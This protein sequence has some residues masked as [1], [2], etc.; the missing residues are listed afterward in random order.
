MA[1]SSSTEAEEND[2]ASVHLGA[3]VGAV[4]AGFIPLNRVPRIGVPYASFL[5]SRRTLAAA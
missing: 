5:S 2:F 1:K 4:H 3:Y